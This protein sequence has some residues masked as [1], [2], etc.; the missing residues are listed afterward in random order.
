[1]YLTDIEAYFKSRNPSRVFLNGGTTEMWCKD[2]LIPDEKI[3]KQACPNL[4][5]DKTFLYKVL[6]EA[7]SI[8]SEEEI[9]IMR[10]A[11][12]ITCEA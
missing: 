5:V 4:E 2:S 3:F 10:W 1:M 6:C 11:S 7:R 8:K 12:R 9:K